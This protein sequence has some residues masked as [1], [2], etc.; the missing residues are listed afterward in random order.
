MTK[1]VGL[2]SSGHK[3]PEIQRCERDPVINSY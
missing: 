3:G 2:V 1:G